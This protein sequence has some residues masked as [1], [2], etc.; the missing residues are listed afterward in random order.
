MNKWFANQ[1]LLLNI[2]IVMSM[3]AFAHAQD[4]QYDRAYLKWKAEQTAQD[5]KLKKVDSN[6]YLS[7]PRVETKN[8]QASASSSKADRVKININ[9]ATVSEFQ[10]LN[11]IGEKKALSI[12]EY[13]E[14]QGKFKTI[15]DLQ[16][17]KGIGPK[18][19]EKNRERLSL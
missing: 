4:T 1:I 15:D 17:V 2:L 13:R 16:N 7:R 6:Y 9:K 8:S 11:G 10:K 18:F 5:E 12:I 14:Q 19:V 3:C